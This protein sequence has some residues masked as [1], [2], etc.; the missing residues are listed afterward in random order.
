MNRLTHCPLS[1]S[2][3]LQQGNVV[4]GVI[5][6]L[7]GLATLN[8]EYLVFSLLEILNQRHFHA[9]VQDMS[10]DRMYLCIFGLSKQ[11][12]QSQFLFMLKSNSV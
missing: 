4:I 12:R 11:E 1:S 8:S 5:T 6:S 7:F 3:N 9:T 2:T 10:R